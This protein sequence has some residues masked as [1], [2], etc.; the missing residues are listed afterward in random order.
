MFSILQKN[1]FHIRARVLIEFLVT[2][3]D[4]Q[5]DIAVAEDTQLHGFLDQTGLTF[6][7]RCLTNW[8]KRSLDE[9]F[10]R[11]RTNESKRKKAVKEKGHT[12]RLRS[13]AIF[14]IAILLRPIRID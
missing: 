3:E 5:R 6:R 13:F 10:V 1:F 14:C 12:W 7:E 4:D 8:N 9:S 2:V 11:Q